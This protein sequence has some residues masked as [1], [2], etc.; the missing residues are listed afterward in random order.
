VKLANSRLLTLDDLKKRGFGEAILTTSTEAERAA[1]LM[2][3]DLAVLG[4][5]F[6]RSEEWLCA[7]TII[8]NGFTVDQYIDAKTTGPQ[9][10]VKFYDPLKGNDGA[11]T[12]DNNHKWDAAGIT[13]IDICDDVY[14]MCRGLTKRG[15]PAQDLLLGSK[16]A[17]VLLRNSDF[18]ELLNKQSGIIVGTV[19]Q[20]LGQYDGITYW[21]T[22]N[23]SGY[24][25][26][27]IVV[28]EQ[29]KAAN[30]TTTNY[31]PATSVAVTA[32]GAGHRM[33]AHIT[34][35][36]ENDQYVTATGMRIPRV[37]TDRRRSTRELIME[38]RPFAAPLNYAPWVYAAN[39]VSA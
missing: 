27:V 5:R 23:F 19:E 12:I 18:R 30:G 9:A 20:T 16:V 21:G 14:A 13:F 4:R 33:Y 29:Y 2:M 11:Y 25:L 26:N 22:I 39:A 34:Y 1:K 3:D 24:R 38:S 37:F 15:L 28:D 32:P 7:Q 10:E 36:N 17:S 6:D 31:F 8:N 35:L